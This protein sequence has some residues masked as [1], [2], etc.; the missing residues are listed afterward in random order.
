MTYFYWFLAFLF[1]AGICSFAYSMIHAPWGGDD[2]NLQ[3]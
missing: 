1:I 3:H 2:E